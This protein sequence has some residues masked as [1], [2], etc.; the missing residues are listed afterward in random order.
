MRSIKNLTLLAIAFVLITLSSCK[1]DN[2]DV[3]STSK[4]NLTAKVNGTVIVF[5]KF[6]VGI[7]GSVNGVDFT[8]VQGTAADGSNMSLTINGA[9]VAGKTYVSSTTDL[10]NSG[11]VLFTTKD[12]E[13]FSSYDNDSGEGSI[14]VTSVSG[15]TIKGTFKGKLKGFLSSSTET[16]TVT[17]GTFT[18]TVTD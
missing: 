9:V 18:V 7:T 12:D 10:E 16:K 5:D 14:T 3:P 2:G 15:K 11:S 4:S 13:T 6:A 8:S 17:E 1:K